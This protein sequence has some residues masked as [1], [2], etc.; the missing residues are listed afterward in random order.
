MSSPRTIGFQPVNT[1]FGF[2]V[3]TPAVSLSVTLRPAGVAASTWARFTNAAV[4]FRRSQSYVT[5]VPA[6]TEPRSRLQFGA[7]R[8]VT[9]TCRSSTLPV[10]VTLMRNLA[11]PS[12]PTLCEL[13]L[14]TIRIAGWAGGANGLSTLTGVR[15]TSRTFVVRP[16]TPLT[17]V[18][19]FTN[20][21]RTFGRSQS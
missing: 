5:D 14:F 18:A 15:A 1:G 8:S 2:L 11:V 12:W 4:T 10:F 19:V 17:T 21:R 6:L 7:P 9:V 3:L 20:P 13:G 16:E